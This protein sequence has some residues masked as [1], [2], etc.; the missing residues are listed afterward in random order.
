MLA[1]LAM[2]TAQSYDRDDLDRWL[3]QQQPSNAIS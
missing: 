1:G 3:G 2:P